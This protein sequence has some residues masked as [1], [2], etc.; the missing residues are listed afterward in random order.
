MGAVWGVAWCMWCSGSAL[1]SSTRGHG[2]NSRHGQ[3]NRTLCGVYLLCSPRDITSTY[4][5]GVVYGV[6]WRMG[7]EC[8]FEGIGSVVWCMDIG[9]M[10]ERYIRSSWVYG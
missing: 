8:G 10:S 2:F 3:K 7:S 6:E 1:Y 4:I 5:G 9:C